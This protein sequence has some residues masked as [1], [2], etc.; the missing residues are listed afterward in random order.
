MIH[1]DYHKMH[2]LATMSLLQS[3]DYLFIVQ[4]ITM[5]GPV[6]PQLAGGSWALATWARSWIYATGSQSQLYMQQLIILK[7]L[8][9]KN[10]KSQ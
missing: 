9:H 2:T 3:R 6:I 7:V 1:Y 4:V 8:K 5:F 10:F